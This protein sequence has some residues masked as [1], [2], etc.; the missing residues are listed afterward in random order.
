MNTVAVTEPVLSTVAGRHSAAAGLVA[1]RAGAEKFDAA[2][3]AP[4]FGLIG[5]PFLAALAATL[6]ARA[7]RL[8][9][10]ARSHT[11]QAVGTRAGDLAYRGADEANAQEVRA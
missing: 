9:A 1:E 2:A 11:D 4:T 10:L 7:G 6:S 8:D 3:L 5:A